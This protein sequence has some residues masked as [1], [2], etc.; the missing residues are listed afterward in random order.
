VSTI[1]TQIRRFL[2]QH[3]ARSPHTA[4][5]YHNGLRRFQE[6]LAEQDIQAD[7]LVDRLTLSLA[8]DFVTWLGGQR[9]QKGRNV[10]ERQLSMRTRQ[11]YAMAVSGLYRQLVLDGLAGFSYGDY[12][13]T[14]DALAKA[15]KFKDVPIEKKLPPDEVMET[16][17]EA[18]QSPPAALAQPNLKESAR[19][20][21]KLVWLRDKAVVLCLYSTGMRIGELLSLRRADLDY[22][23]RGTWVTGKGDRTRF[24]RFSNQAWQALIVY[25]GERRDE[26]ISG[27]LPHMPVICRHDRAAGDSRRLSMSS[28]MAERI[29]T[30]LAKEA[31]VLARFNLTPHSFR[32]YFATRFLR[33]TGDLALTQDVLGHASPMTTRIYAKTTKEQHIAAHVSLFD[34]ETGDDE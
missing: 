29:I 6:F 5:T 14:H 9:Y 34:E 33:H 32:H 3:E 1:A 20:R 12:L 13:A 8:R 28:V 22:T 26:T 15:T 21:L 18:I 25:L 17:V 16:I 30:N 27:S 31:G 7:A 4:K 10:P 24:V 2:D 11:N 19:R 23:D